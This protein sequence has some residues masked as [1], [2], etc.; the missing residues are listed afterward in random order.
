MELKRVIA[1]DM[2]TA[3]E[4]AIQLYGE[5][6]L[7]ISSE[8]VDN[9]TEL[10]VAVDLPSLSEA[11]ST[12]ADTAVHVD[13]NHDTGVDEPAG[14]IDRF[15]VEATNAPDTDRPADLA[16][17]APSVSSEVMSA[18]EFRRVSFSEALEASSRPEPPPPTPVV[19]NSEAMIEAKHEALQ[20]REIVAWLR[21]EF[22]ALKRELLGARWQ[23]DQTG[24][25]EWVEPMR[26]LAQALAS[27]GL[28]STVRHLLMSELQALQSSGRLQ[29]LESALQALEDRLLSSLKIP[30]FKQQLSGLQILAGPS[31]SGKTT[32]VCRLA[33][34]AAVASGASSQAIVSY[35]DTR[36]GAWSQLQTLCAQAGIDC[37]RAPDEATF[38]VILAELSDRKTVWVD[39]PGLNFMDIAHGLK[40]QFSSACLHAVLPVDATLTS[41]ARV[42]VQ[43]HGLWTSLM[44]TKMDE[45]AHPWPLIAA[46]TEYPTPVSCVCD[47]ATH[48]PRSF[49]VQE[50]VRGALR[51]LYDLPMRGTP[52]AQAPSMVPPPV[53][54]SSHD[55]V[56]DTPSPVPAPVAVKA[57]SRAVKAV[58]KTVAK[59]PAKAPAKTAKK[60]SSKE[61]QKSAKPATPKA[62]K[63]P[64][65]R[66]VVAKRSDKVVAKVTP[67]SPTRRV[68]A[69]A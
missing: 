65:T 66:K 35:R 63:A 9:H 38:Q 18:A 8:R 54:T 6:V 20:S 49:K 68:A 13:F 64:A 14:D 33:S 4:K 62:A 46:L 48:M 32:L 34:Q 58:A 56:I 36:P 23:M 27:L 39:T 19:A 22:D 55:I 2:R 40:S 43:A 57:K 3:N 12:S 11:S 28:P 1:L 47:G 53:T 60:S 26:S 51:P 21:E 29:S 59:A 50:L 25:Q 45:A 17:A 10:I 41:S 5:N 42:V 31:G 16:G 30:A 61:L 7:V 24:A 67:K 15:N 37:Y 69:H 44:L 52:V